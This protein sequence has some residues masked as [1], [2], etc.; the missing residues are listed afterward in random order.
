MLNFV[1]IA[2][3]AV[4]ALSS[5]FGIARGLVKEV[6][7]L[8]VWI[9][10]IV[11]AYQYSDSLS[12]MLGSVTSNAT[13]QY[14]LAFAIIVI[15][16][17]IGGSIVNAFMSR[18]VNFAGLQASDRILGAAFGMVRGVVICAIV[19]YFAASVYSQE[20]WWQESL[21]LPYIEGVIDW[22]QVKSGTQPVSAAT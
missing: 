12:P 15:A 17:L 22:V 14:A 5:L 4:I 21:T 16:V 20:P 2:I 6:L 11:I 9:A 19:V 3:L 13:A 7:S 18:L 8:L 10:A 1:D